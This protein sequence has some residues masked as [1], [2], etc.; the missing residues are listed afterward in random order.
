MTDRNK[1]VLRICTFD[2]VEDKK[3]QKYFESSMC[4]WKYNEDLPFLMCCNYNV[5]VESQ[6]SSKKRLGMTGPTL[7][8]SANSKGLF[9]ITAKNSQDTVVSFISSSKT[10]QVP[11]GLDKTRAARPSQKLLS[12]RVSPLDSSNSFLFDLRSP[13][14]LIEMPGSDKKADGKRSGNKSGSPG[15]NSPKEACRASDAMV[16][17]NQTGR[18]QAGS[19]APSTSEGHA[20]R[21]RAGRHDNIFASFASEFLV[22]VSAPEQQAPSKSA[23]PPSQPRQKAV[24][25]TK[26][27]V[28]NDTSFQAFM[29][30]SRARLSSTGTKGEVSPQK[31]SNTSKSDGRRSPRLSQ[32]DRTTLKSEKNDKASVEALEEAMDTESDVDKCLK[33]QMVPRRRSSDS[34]SDGEVPDL[35]VARKHVTKTRKPSSTVEKVPKLSKFNGAS[36][37]AVNHQEESCEHVEKGSEMS[38]DQVSLRVDPDSDNDAPI[39]DQTGCDDPPDIVDLPAD[40]TSVS[41]SEQEVIRDTPRETVVMSAPG[42]GRSRTRGSRVRGLSHGYSGRGRG[43][44]NSQ[45]SITATSLFT[46]TEDSLHKNCSTLTPNI[47]SQTHHGASNMTPSQLSQLGPSGLKPTPAKKVPSYPPPAKSKSCVSLAERKRK[48]SLKKLQ[49]QRENEERRNTIGSSNPSDSDSYTSSDLYSDSP[50]SHRLAATDHSHRYPTPTTPSAEYSPESFHT[51]R[52]SPGTSTLGESSDIQSSPSYRHTSSHLENSR[53]LFKCRGL[54]GSLKPSRGGLPARRITRGGGGGRY[55]RNRPERCSFSEDETV[56]VSVSNVVHYYNG[57]RVSLQGRKTRHMAEEN[58]SRVRVLKEDCHAYKLTD[59]GQEKLDLHKMKN[60]ELADCEKYKPKCDRLYRKYK[61]DT[62]LIRKPPGRPPGWKKQQNSFS[63][64][65]ERPGTSPSSGVDV[66]DTDPVI[67]GTVSLKLNTGRPPPSKVLDDVSL[68]ARDRKRKETITHSQTSLL[69]AHAAERI[70]AAAATVKSS[71]QT[72]KH[73][74]SLSQSAPSSHYR[75]ENTSK[76]QPSS[77]VRHSSLDNNQQQQQQ[78]EKGDMSVVDFS[79]L[80]NPMDNDMGGLASTDADPHRQLHTPPLLMDVDADAS[81]QHTGSSPHTSEVSTPHRTEE[82]SPSESTPEKKAPRERK[83]DEQISSSDEDDDDGRHTVDDTLTETDLYSDSNVGQGSVNGDGDLSDSSRKITAI[84]SLVKQDSFSTEDSL[85]SDGP[86][87]KGARKAKGGSLKLM[88]RKVNSGSSTEA[89]SQCTEDDVRRPL[90]KR[91]KYEQSDSYKNRSKRTTVDYSSDVNSRKLSAEKQQHQTEKQSAGDKRRKRTKQKEAIHY[92]II[93]RFRG[94]KSMRVLLE[95]LYIDKNQSIHL[96]DL[97]KYRKRKV[98]KE[99]KG[100]GVPKFTGSFTCKHK[101]IVSDVPHENQSDPLWEA[102]M[103][104]LGGDNERDSGRS[105][106]DESSQDEGSD[107]YRSQRA[108]P[109][110]GAAASKVTKKPRVASYHK[111]LSNAFCGKTRRP[112]RKADQNKIWNTLSLL[113]NATVAQ[114]TSPHATYDDGVD[115]DHSSEYMD[116]MYKLALY[117]PPQSE[118]GGQSPPQP[119][120]PA[121]SVEDYEALVQQQD[122]GPRK[123]HAHIKQAK[124]A[125]ASPSLK[126]DNQSDK[127]HSKNAK[128]AADSPSGSDSDA[129]FGRQ[130]L[131]S[132]YNSTGMNPNNTGSPYTVKEAI[133]RFNPSKVFGPTHKGSPCYS[134]DFTP[135]DLGPPSLHQMS[136]HSLGSNSGSPPELILHDSSLAANSS[137]LDPY[138]NFFGNVATGPSNNRTKPEHNSRR[139]SAVNTQPKTAPV[140]NQKHFPSRESRGTDKQEIVPT[141]DKEVVVSNINKMPVC[142]QKKDPLTNQKFK[143]GDASESGEQNKEKESSK[144]GNGKNDER[145]TKQTSVSSSKNKAGKSQEEVAPSTSTKGGTD[146]TGETTKEKNPR[147]NRRSLSL[148]K[149][150]DNPTH[151]KTKEEA[152]KKKDEEHEARGQGRAG[153]TG[154][155]K[156]PTG[157][158]K[159][160]ARFGVDLHAMKKQAEAKKQTNMNTEGQESAGDNPAKNDGNGKGKKEENDAHKSAVEKGEDEDDETEESSEEEEDV[161][162]RMQSPPQSPQADEPSDLLTTDPKEVKETTSSEKR[163]E[164]TSDEDSEVENHCKKQRHMMSPIRSPSPT[165]FSTG[166]ELNI[167]IVPIATPLHTSTVGQDYHN[168]LH[169]PTFPTNRPIF[170]VRYSRTA[171]ADWKRRRPSIASPPRQTSPP[172]TCSPTEDMIQHPKT[173]EPKSVYVVDKSCPSKK[174][175]LDRDRVETTEAEKKMQATLEESTEESEEESEDEETRRERHVSPIRSPSPELLSPQEEEAPPPRLKTQDVSSDVLFSTPEGPCPAAKQVQNRTLQSQSG[176]VDLFSPE[177]SYGKAETTA[178]DDETE[179]KVVA[180]SL[181]A[182]KDDESME[183]EEEEESEEE[184]CERVSVPI[185]SP[186]PDRAY[187]SVPCVDEGFNE[188][189]AKINLNRGKIAVGAPKKGDLNVSTMSKSDMFSSSHNETDPEVNIKG[190]EKEET[191]GQEG[192]KEVRTVTAGSFTKPQVANKKGIPTGR[193]AGEFGEDNQESEEEEVPR[194]RTMIPI[195]SPSPEPIQSPAHSNIQI[196]VGPSDIPTSLIGSPSASEMII[197]PKEHLILAQ[198]SPLVIE[199][200]PRGRHRTVKKLASTSPRKG[201]GTRSRYAMEP[202][203]STSPKKA[204]KARYTET[205]Q[206]VRQG[207]R[208]AKESR[209]SRFRRPMMSP[210]PPRSEREEGEIRTDD[211][212]LESEEEREPPPPSIQA[213]APAKPRRQQKR[214]EEKEEGELTETDTALSTPGHSPCAAIS[215]DDEPVGTSSPKPVQ[216]QRKKS[217]QTVSHPVMPETLLGTEGSVKPSEEQ[218]QQVSDPLLPATSPETLS[219]PL[220]KSPPLLSSDVLAS[221]NSPVATH[222]LAQR[223]PQETN[224]AALSQK[225]SQPESSLLSTAILQDTTPASNV[226]PTQSDT[227]IL[228]VTPDQTG[229]TSD[230]E[231]N[232]SQGISA[233]TSEQNDLPETNT[234]IAVSKRSAVP[235]IT[236][237][238]THGSSE[239]SCPDSPLTRFSQVAEE[240]LP[241]EPVQQSTAE[242]QP[243]RESESCA[244]TQRVDEISTG[245][246]TV[247]KSSE[248]VSGVIGEGTREDEESDDEDDSE[249]EDDEEGDSDSDTV[250]EHVEC[251]SPIRSP[252]PQPEASCDLL[253]SVPARIRVEESEYVEGEAVSYTE[254][255]PSQHLHTKHSDGPSSSEDRVEGQASP[256]QTCSGDPGNAAK[257]KSVSNLV[258][259]QTSQEKENSSLKPGL[260]DEGQDSDDGLSTSQKVEDKIEETPE[261]P[262]SHPTSAVQISSPRAEK[263]PDAEEERG[264]AVKASDGKKDSDKVSEEGS[265]SEDEDE[266]ESSSDEEDGRLTPV[267]IRSPA[268]SIRSPSPIRSPEAEDIAEPDETEDIKSP[269]PLPSSDD[270]RRDSGYGNQPPVIPLTIDTSVGDPR[271]RRAL[272]PHLPSPLHRENRDDQQPLS[273]AERCYRGSQQPPAPPPRNSQSRPESSHGEAERLQRQSGVEVSSGGQDERHPSDN[274][275]D[276]LSDRAMSVIVPARPPPSRRHVIDTART[277]GRQ[278]GAFFSDPKDAVQQRP[279]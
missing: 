188:D 49:K 258:D 130:A 189:R 10:H 173:E 110:G 119:M 257:D 123:P 230:V 87:K 255:R 136:P 132:E 38:D 240:R 120:S 79:V 249:E 8:S 271:V 75:N 18:R 164:I 156:Q 247:E 208:P 213:K 89:H 203:G 274:A 278:D 114:L 185:R 193:L 34:S 140:K 266:D 104:R 151:E 127:S 28:V 179:S 145:N 25:P 126:D 215:M 199:T 3:I 71:S 256:R 217:P 157:Y 6:S 31:G 66:M 144:S 198:K 84:K 26:T 254:S 88:I 221:G 40:P 103:E 180:A 146:N 167:P 212:P 102:Q 112:K 135:P 70:P 154:K 186:S 253:S 241:F 171:P 115:N 124:A 170:P 178:E 168:I 183:E 95:R 174:S 52:S 272:H 44:Y 61:V 210:Q 58:L 200:D 190:Q 33:P 148:R 83:A 69:P 53:G 106:D 105:S 220:P 76:A 182:N 59:I 7:S 196:T 96:K 2:E 90:K 276:V 147:R 238:A 275:G 160:V 36:P 109:F 268:V 32:R 270:D 269:S 142:T 223:L 224:T 133:V 150:K 68:E 4:E 97:N 181:L 209:S 246:E 93:N 143:P 117:S 141:K 231:P 252:S 211:E 48:L 207:R 244:S 12:R 225:S 259:V 121:A 23:S 118:H 235:E 81:S 149:S 279:R 277:E 172:R 21:S 134:K 169:S 100:E 197:T 163:K 51:S 72:L 46:N 56:W 206:D 204:L 218:C 94:Y 47:S 202:P 227:Q 216:D 78:P 139:K 162:V 239:I 192:I 16:H 85:A 17:L 153:V 273:D 41:D 62:S 55:P 261:G 262:S 86:S 243:D 39:F 11:L 29:Q 77:L 54:K 113:H 80:E 265:S 125:N 43:S 19:G 20:R 201:E 260:V 5:F 122:E 175:K 82:N 236:D 250:P 161:C 99:S 27:P 65:S 187:P 234:E 131:L 45:G 251:S 74:P 242:R 92:I 60:S 184:E 15:K 22:P 98:V 30:K 267:S 73:I 101:T 67:A 176:S 228:R 245:R 263:I 138:T 57:M 194:T 24:S 155:S 177:E 158:K 14:G 42:R 137:S 233:E 116:V 159:G 108:G 1:N 229:D 64:D 107:E 91:R 219:A 214:K 264:G 232:R 128:A 205:Q 237:T 13:G 166:S 195:R 152:L 9:S 165:H 50:L 111:R 222:N 37:G 226:F 129:H 191:V 248:K 35:V 63:S